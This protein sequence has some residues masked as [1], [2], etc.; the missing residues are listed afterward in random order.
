MVW[1]G[2]VWYGML[3]YGKRAGASF[4]PALACLP[5]CLS[6]TRFPCWVGRYFSLLALSLLRVCRDRA[7]DTN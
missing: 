3:C 1:Y 7:M 2:M 6:G 4:L 5:A